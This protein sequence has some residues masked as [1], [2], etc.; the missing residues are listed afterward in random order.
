MKNLLLTR[1]NFR[2]GVF[3]RDN[4]QCVICKEPAKDAHHII[5]HR[6]F[7]DGGYYI[8]NG[9]SLCETHHI[10]AEMTTLSCEEIREKCKIEFIVL[11][12]HFYSDMNYDKWGNVILPNGNRLK[13]ELFDDISVQKILEKG[14]VLDLFQPY[15]K[16]PR[17]YHL[18]ESKMGKDDRQLEDDSLLIG[19]EVVVTIKLDGE[20]TSAYPD[21]VHA[22]SIDGTSHESRSWVR[23]FLFQNVCW[24]L[25][26]GM[27][28]CGENLYA[29]HSIEYDE[30]K[31]YFYLFSVWNEMTCLSWDE[32]LEYAT[33]LNLEVVPQMYRGIY[34]KEKIFKEYNTNWKGPK[35]EGFV[36][37]LADSFLYKDFRK[38]V[39]KFV[40]PSFRQVVN[41][42]HGHWI[43][44]K[45]TPN[46]LKDAAGS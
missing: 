8:N 21:Y 31:S 13:G 33:L 15:I 29:K 19:K 27:R 28:I 12:E 22:R 9:A 34:D 26:P 16:Y 3:K 42:A 2:E 43:S 20:N 38:S 18:P 17:T 36:L 37:R 11:P 30:L 32:T 14:K 10:E 5:E 23:G 35:T 46:K 7:T 45:I 6:L 44:Q 24:Q 40:E 1:D 41:S 39:A 4:Y 25:S